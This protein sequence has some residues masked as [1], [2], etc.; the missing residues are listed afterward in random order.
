MERGVSG[1]ST[2]RSGTRL[3]SPSKLDARVSSRALSLSTG[4]WMVVNRTSPSAPVDAMAPVKGLS[5]LGGLNLHPWV[6]LCGGKCQCSLLTLWSVTRATESPSQQPCCS[7]PERC[8]AQT[9]VLNQGGCTQNM[10]QS[11]QAALA[12]IR[13]AQQAR[14][15]LTAWPAVRTAWN[16]RQYYCVHTWTA[17]ESFLPW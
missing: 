8:G 5:G 6:G 15:A 10:Q 9:S 16:L 11:Q 17:E 12:K 14:D 7:L 13:V 3:V 2:G 4:G 1:E